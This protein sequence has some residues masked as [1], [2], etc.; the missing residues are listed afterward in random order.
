M[1]RGKNPVPWHVPPSR[2][3]LCFVRYHY[4]EVIYALVA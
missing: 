4:L 3:D 1:K 2:Q